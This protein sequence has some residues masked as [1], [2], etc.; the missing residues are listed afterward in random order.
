MARFISLVRSTV[1]HAAATALFAA[2][3]L[4]G[5][6]PDAATAVIR[7]VDAGGRVSYQDKTCPNGAR[8]A[9]VD[10]RPNMGPE[11][12]GREQ[13]ERERRAAEARERA[14]RRAKAAAAARAQA[15]SKEK[16]PRNAAER[17][18]LKTGMYAAEVRRR[19]GPPDQIVRPMTID[20]TATD[21]K[22]SQQWVYLPAAEDPQTTT[23]VTVRRGQVLHVERRVAPHMGG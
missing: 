2:A 14:E 11:F 17:Q 8:G 21:F 7:C 18:F 10:A 12:V 13:L 9:P 23:I 1:A 16:K 5:W 15:A 3:P 22:A 4:L 6:S 19:F 20:R